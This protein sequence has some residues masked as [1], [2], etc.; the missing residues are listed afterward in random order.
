MVRTSSDEPQDIDRA[1]DL[2]AN[3][4]V[5]KPSDFTGLTAV[6][7]K[8]HDYWLETNLAPCCTPVCY[9]RVA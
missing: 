2:G 3:S 8:V 7:Q 4:F 1:Y 9:R 6:S 5:K